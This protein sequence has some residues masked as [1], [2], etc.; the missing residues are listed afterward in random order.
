[1]HCFQFVGQL[2]EINF[3]KTIDLDFILVKVYK[4]YKSLNS[5]G[6][7]NVD[8]LPRQ[9]QIF[10]QTVNLEILEENLLDSI[11]VYGD[12]FLTDVFNISNVN[13]S[14][15]S[16]LFLFSYAVAMFKNVNGTGNVS[17]FL[18]DSTCRNGS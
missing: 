5:P 14:S 9:V 18:F 8:Q 15:G 6:Y 13:N 17:Y 16:I 2:S 11:A 12:P 1:M 10:T 4:L 7:L 3:W